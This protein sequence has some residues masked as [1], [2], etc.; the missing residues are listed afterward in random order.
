MASAR[1]AT[2]YVSV[3]TSCG[4]LL[5]I[6]VEQANLTIEPRGFLAGDHHAQLVYKTVVS[7]T[8]GI[9]CSPW[10]CADRGMCGQS[11]TQ[12]LEQLL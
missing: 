11:A 3:S 9:S 5:Q 4:L 2:V 12:D 1:Q 8:H 7:S 10:M 6:E